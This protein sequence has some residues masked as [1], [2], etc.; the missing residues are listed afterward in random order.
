MDAGLIPDSHTSFDARFAYREV[1][2]FA[3]IALDW[4]MAAQMASEPTH[5]SNGFP[6]QS[7]GAQVTQDGWSCARKRRRVTGVGAQQ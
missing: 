5:Q 2:R 1:M 6:A 4:M 7:D 3:G